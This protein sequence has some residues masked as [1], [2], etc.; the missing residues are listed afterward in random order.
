[1]TEPRPREPASPLVRF[2]VR[3]DQPELGDA[4]AQLREDCHLTRPDLIQRM[5]DVSEGDLG[6]DVSL[7]FRWEVGEQGKPRVRPGPRYRALLGQVCEREVMDLPPIARRDFLRKL[8]GL[9]GPP[10]LLTAIPDTNALLG[11]VPWKALPRGVDEVGADDVH[12]VEH[13]RQ[14]RALLVES[15]NLFGPASVIPAVEAHIQTIQQLREGLSGADDRSLLQMRAQ[16]AEF[17]GWLYQ[18]AGQWS[19]AQYWLDR[20]LEWSH[21][22][23]DL[24]M[25]TYVLA[26]KSQLAG[27]M[28]DAASAVD[29][30]GAAATMAPP[31]GRLQAVAPTYAAHGFALGGA[32]ADCLRAL[33]EA[34]DLVEHLDEDPPSQWAPWLD[35]AYIDVQRGRCLA[36]LGDHGQAVGVFQQAIRE[37][38]PAYRRDR[39][40][41]L[42]REAL[43]HAGNREPEE[44]AAVGMRALAI[45]QQTQSGRIVKELASL[46]QQLARWARVRAVAALREALATVVPRGGLAR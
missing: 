32:A 23:A 17:A 5:W 7:V 43:A 26:R 41:Y 13:L 20:A 9:V 8:T 6:V 46:D 27:D 36:I 38:P 15:D 16:F 25:T 19:A 39:G 37:L 1:M 3:L 22:V 28:G 30:A 14:L 42:G 4:I 45:A 34:R 24:Q 11:L 44:A 18:D 21:A 31:R 2:W 35:H 12:P 10:L 40:V 29:L 33:D